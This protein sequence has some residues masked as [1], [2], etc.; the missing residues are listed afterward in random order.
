MRNLQIDKEFKEHVE[1]MTL[2]KNDKNE[3]IIKTKYTSSDEIYIF[4]IKAKRHFNKLSRL[5]RMGKSQLEYHE[6]KMKGQRFKL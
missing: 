6:D 1:Y 4:Y 5:Y 2:T 3:Y